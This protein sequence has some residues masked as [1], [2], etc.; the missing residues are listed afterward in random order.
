MLSKWLRGRSIPGSK[1]GHA[2]LRAPHSSEAW[3]CRTCPAPVTSRNAEVGSKERA[4]TACQS[5]NVFILA[6][7][8]M[9]TACLVPEEKHRWTYKH[10]L[11]GWRLVS[12]CNKL[13]GWGTSSPAWR[14]CE[15]D[16][17]CISTPRDLAQL[18]SGTFVVQQGL[19]YDPSQNTFRNGAPHIIQLDVLTLCSSTIVP[20][21]SSCRCCI[22]G[23]WLL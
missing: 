22:I 2:V 16:G 18:T 20:T 1:P 6:S 19:I 5:M 10:T 15:L 7:D 21:G 14:S 23:R 8:Q 3:R 12:S 17:W 9:N 11:V 4:W 13:S